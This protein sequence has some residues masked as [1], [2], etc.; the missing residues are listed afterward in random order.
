MGNIL[1]PKGV[2]VQLDKERSI[3]F[4]LNAF[5][6]LED[7]YGTIEDAMAALEKGSLKAVRAILWA[8]LVHEDIQ[9]TEK[10]V[11]S[12]V[13][14]PDLPVL[15]EAIKQAFEEAMPAEMKEEMEQAA[16]DPNTKAPKKAPGTGEPSTTQ[17]Q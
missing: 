6:E 4:D 9:L 17:Q 14:L 13:T 1:R 15:S 5:A 7:L 10:K 16:A 8:G 11:G 3:L 12:L 2:N